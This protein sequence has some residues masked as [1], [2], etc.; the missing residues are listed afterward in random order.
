MSPSRCIETNFPSLSG[1]IEFIIMRQSFGIRRVMKRGGKLL[2]LKAY[3]IWDF[4][5]ILGVLMEFNGGF[6]F[7]FLEM[8]TGFLGV[9]FPSG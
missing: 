2:L 7:F 6:V 3:G 9:I 1:Q 8:C 5:G 4:M